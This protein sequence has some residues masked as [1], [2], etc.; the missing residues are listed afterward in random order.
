MAQVVG[1]TADQLAA[2]DRGDA[3]E[4]LRG[5]QTAAAE[6]TEQ[7][8]AATVS[9]VKDEELA[10]ILGPDL[11]AAAKAQLT[12]GISEVR[13]RNRRQFLIEV[14]ALADNFS[15]GDESRHAG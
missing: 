2:V 1:V 13:E 7:S 14:R 4:V 8:P 15:P 11:S 5:M 10:E 3:A 12:A 9:D 6:R